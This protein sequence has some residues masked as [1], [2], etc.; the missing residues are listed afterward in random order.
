MA[1]A[2]SMK[3]TLRPTG[4]EVI[5]N[6]PWG[7]HFCHFYQTEEDL[8][9]MQVPFFQTGLENNEYC[10]W[11]T[12]EQTTVENAINALKA[13]VPDLDVYYKRESIEILSHRDWYLTNGRFELD[14]VIQS[15]LD[16]LRIALDRGFEGLRLN[17][18]EAWMDDKTWH[19]FLEYESSLNPAIAGKR[20][21]I[22]CSYQLAKCTA[23]N[24]LD[25]ALLHESVVSKRKGRW[26]ILE[27]PQ[28]IETKAQ[29]NLER[30]LLEKRFAKSTRELSRITQQVKKERSERKKAMV[31]LR[32]SQ[33][34]LKTIV[35][36]ADIAFV[37]FDSD[38]HALL[39]NTIASYW[40]TLSFGVP[41]KKDIYFPDLLNEKGRSRFSE[42]MDAVLSGQ[43]LN[44]E[45]SYQSQDDSPEW[46]QVSIHPVMDDDGKAV[47]VSCAAS[48]IT[49]DK[50]V[51]SEHE[52]L[53]GQWVQRNKDLDKFAFILSHDLRAPLANMLGLAKML[54]GTNVSE[55][56]K[57]ELEGLLFQ[58]IEKLDDVVHNLNRIL[59]LDRTP[60]LKKENIDL[61]ELVNEVSAQLK[62]V[63]K[64]NAIRMVTDFNRANNINSVRGYL[65]NIFYNLISNSIIFGLQMKPPVIEITSEKEKD[66]LIIYFK[67]FG[68]ANYLKGKKT[69]H[70]SYK[71]INVSDKS[72]G[73]VLYGVK[74]KI[75]FLG[76]SIS[77]RTLPGSGKEFRMELPFE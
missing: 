10:I 16:R 41:L 25:I 2:L 13:K 28:L 43:S 18:D 23:T 21:I 12:S 63:I 40:S 15:I 77:V 65:Y 22:S 4:I 9:S 47:G 67:S 73:T 19:D 55:S 74:N 8:L 50:L 29:L 52:R 46:Y 45:A 49:R 75:E 6:I 51:E 11:V 35:D 1:G 66:R 27:T 70:V 56:E 7:T 30:E 42:M 20:L 54:K 26:E 32:K 53:S 17:G 60:S 61:T 3:Q 37:L 38:S 69:E 14:N 76:G 68:K 57:S 62:P 39:F 59:E 48:N 24:V 33:L 58:S 31:S 71:K 44:Y 72:N 64:Q 34:H 36:T 5:G